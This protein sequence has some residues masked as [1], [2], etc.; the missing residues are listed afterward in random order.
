M[1]SASKGRIGRA[2]AACAGLWLTAGPGPGGALAAASDW[3]RTEVSQVRLI[4]ATAAVGTAETLRLGLQFR[5]EPGWKIYWRSPGDAGTPP[6]LDFSGSTNLAGAEMTWPAPRRFFEAADL[7]TVGYLDEVVL[8]LAVRPERPGAPVA[9]RAR[10]DYQVCELICIPVTAQLALEL[11]A[12]PAAATPFTQLIERYQARVPGAPAAAGIEVVE[13]GVTGAPPAQTLRLVARSAVPFTAPE[14]FVEAPDIFRLPAGRATLGARGGEVTLALPVEARDG[15][16]LAGTPVVL[17]LVDGE[18]AAEMALTLEPLAAAAGG[19]GLAVMLALALLGGLIL[20]LMPCVLPV[21]SLKL[22]GVIGHG[23]GERRRVT[24]SFV[25][26]A[27]GIVVSFLVLAGA[28]VAVKLAG[29]AVG[30]GM[31]FQ[32]PGFLVFVILVL[33]LF[34]YN[35]I[36][37]YQV[38]LPGW[39]GDL[40][41]AA[42]DRAERLGGGLAGHFM[43]GAFATLLATPCSAPFLG[44]AVSFALGRGAGEILAVFAALGLGMSAPYLLVAAFPGLATRLPRPGRWMAWVLAA[45]ALAL[46]GTAAWLV[47][48]LAAIAGWPAAGAVAG[49]LLLAAPAIRIARAQGAL[50]PLGAGALAVLLAAAFAAPAALESPAPQSRPGATAEAVDWRPFDADAIAPAVAAGQVVFVDVTADWCV[51]CKVNKRVVLD[52]DEVAARL[53][54]PWVVRMRADWTRP[55]QRIADYLASFDRYGI[56]FN[57]VYGPG[58]PDG[59]ALSELLTRA[60]VSS[61]LDAARGPVA[62]AID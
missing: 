18:R 41:L 2:L 45:L 49:V 28:A 40:G 16:D 38:R 55:D 6:R 30:W 53:T 25:A 42:G 52:S 17:T 44:T 11:P 13:V 31:Q 4:S 32:Q 9:L 46:L 19:D 3:A 51:T 62:A 47:T 48:V 58:V 21:L 35:L 43:T 56:P 61:A 59:R 1:S 26:S 22:L 54:A 33:G 24:L 12:G 23:G 15:A 29:G 39:L 60:E 14:L 57:A 5:L 50:R 37:L 34:A 8:P 20:N 10:L 7:E 36:G 27:A